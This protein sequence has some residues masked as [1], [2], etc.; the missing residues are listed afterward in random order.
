MSKKTTLAVVVAI[1]VGSFLVALNQFGHT[2]MV[3]YVACFASGIAI[4]AMFDW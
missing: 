4:R 2:S 1:V 3:L